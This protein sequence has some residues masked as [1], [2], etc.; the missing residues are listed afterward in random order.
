MAYKLCVLCVEFP[1][2]TLRLNQP[3][4]AQSVTQSA[5]RKL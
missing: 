2:R 1:L 5:Q 4:S 3:Q